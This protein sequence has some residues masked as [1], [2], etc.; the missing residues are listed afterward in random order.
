MQTEE[1]K[2]RQN[3]PG[4]VVLDRD[5]GEE[6]IP[7]K[8][9]VRE[10]SSQGCEIVEGSKLSDFSGVCGRILFICKPPARS[11]E[12]RLDSYALYSV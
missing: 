1:D 10:Q 11:S 12:A 6:I 8:F 5:F 2:A 4:L 9:Y 7:E 3:G